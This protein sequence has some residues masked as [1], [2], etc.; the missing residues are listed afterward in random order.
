ME[1]LVVQSCPIVI[2]GD[3]DIHVDRSDDTY[4]VRSGQLPQSFGLVQHVK[5]PTHAAGHTLDLVITK[6]RY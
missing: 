3:F 6:E 1:R 5:E 4:A 2:C